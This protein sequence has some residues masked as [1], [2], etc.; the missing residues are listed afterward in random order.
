LARGADGNFLRDEA[1]HAVLGDKPTEIPIRLLYD[2]PAINFPSRY[3]CF[4]GRSLFCAGDGETAVRQINGMGATVECTCE[5]ADLAYGGTDK[6]KMNGALS[7]MIDG[8]G[9]LG[10][11][12]KFRTTSYNSILGIM[13]SLSFLRSVTGGPLAGLPLKLVI[14]EKQGV[15]PKGEPVTIFVVAVEFAGDLSELMAHGHRVALERAKTHMSITH[16][17]DEARRVLALA[18]P[19]VPLPG[20][21]VDDVV[22]EFYPA[23]AVVTDAPPRPVKP[24]AAPLETVVT[25]EELKPFKLP[26]GEGAD[27]FLKFGQAFVSAIKGAA[28]MD[29]IAEWQSLNMESL[30]E[31]Q[32]GAPKAYGSISS[33]IV[34]AGAALARA[35][36]GY[37]SE[38]GEIA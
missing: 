10:G 12:W 5:R 7:V 19:D 6:C 28:T 16:I 13:S 4:V 29:E 15:T 8:V 32:R 9:G 14:R 38:T 2:D 27:R 34:D 21:I 18:P 33:A 26:F 22:E 30:I 3:A 24:A 11:V 17:E 36:P 20:D 25:Y 37:D 35:E 1:I 23:Q 31:V